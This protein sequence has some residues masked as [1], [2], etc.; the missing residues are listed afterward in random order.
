M[1]GEVGVAIIDD[2][3]Q[4]LRR[5]EALV[6]EIA[7]LAVIGSAA[8]PLAALD[9]VVSL[10]PPIIIL[11]LSLSGGSGTDVLKAL[12]RQAIDT[13]VVVVSG[14]PSAHLRSI[15]LELGARFV[16]DKAFQFGELQGALRDL[17]EEVGTRCSN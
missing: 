17:L 11:D 16:F 12:A 10:R 13:R 6:A 1:E 3:A 8:T 7:G 14:F 9:L 15:C 2:S 4:W 5:L